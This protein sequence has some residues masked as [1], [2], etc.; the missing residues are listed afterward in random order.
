VAVLWIDLNKFKQTNDVHGHVAGDAVLKEVALRL[1]GRLRESDTI[2]RMGGDEFMA[3][4]QGVTGRADAERVAE[5]L[6]LSL[7]APIPFQQIMLAASASIGISMYPEDGESADLL[8][9]NADMAMYEAKFGHHGV[10]VF[11]PALD[12]VLSER[13]ELAKAMAEALE[14]GGFVLHYQPQ[15]GLGGDLAGFEALLRLPHPVMGM[16]PPARLIPVAEESEMIFTLGKW[17]IREA[18]RQSLRWQSAGHRPVTMAVNIS[19]MQFAR[20]DFADHVAEVLTETGLDPQLLELELTESV[21]VKDFAESTKQLQRLKRLGVS[22]AVDDFG[23]GYSSLQQLNRTPIT[24]LKLDRSFVRRMSTH[25][26]AL[27]IVESMI[28]LS[29][30]LKLKTVAEGI[31]SE[32]QRNRLAELGCETGQGFLFA[33]PLDHE[34]FEAWCR[35]KESIAA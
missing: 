21:M 25:P 17:V 13:R 22:I 18:C 26:K 34:T 16:I 8:E 29:S 12:I 35:E 24:E 15:Y 20:Q 14:T 30:K 7:A 23:T 32:W 10:R 28:D 2:A 31:D 1:S 4:L 6:L 11:S 27:S 5:Q 19:S 9:R 3:V 33:K